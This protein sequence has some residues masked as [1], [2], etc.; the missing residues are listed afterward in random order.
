[1]IFK[2]EKQEKENVECA[3]ALFEVQPTF[4]TM[5]NNASM[6]RVEILDNGQE[7]SLL[8]AYDIGRDLGM[9]KMAN[10]YEKL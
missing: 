3:C 6:L 7:I 9:Q 10:V 2:I 5:E 1:M 8:T 4:Y